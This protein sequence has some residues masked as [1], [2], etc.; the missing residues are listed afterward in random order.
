MLHE[1][2]RPSHTPL[3]TLLVLLAGAWLAAAGCGDA[4][5]PALQVDGLEWSEEELVGLTDE[6]QM[7]LAEIAALGLA[8]RRDSLPALVRPVVERETRRRLATVLRAEEA[9]GEADVGD[10]VLR[11]RY[12]TDPAWE[13]TV[14]HLIVLSERWESET[15]RREARAKAE[16]ALQRIRAGEDFPSVAA[17]VSEE[18]GAEGREGLLTPGRRGAWVPEFWNAAMT[19]D[20]GEV[21][22]VVETPYGF[23]VLRLEGR[24]TVPFE[25][26]RTEVA[27]EV[28]ELLGAD[29]DAPPPLPSGLEVVS[30]PGGLLAD[31]DAPD[32]TTVAVWSDGRLSLADLRDH[33]ATLL[34]PAAR[35]LTSSPGAARSAVETAARE[36]HAA[37]R[38]RERGIRVSDAWVDETTREWVDRAARWGAVL[39]LRAD[40]SDEQLR[41]AARRALGMTGQEARVAREELRERNPLIHHRYAIRTS[42]PGETSR[43]GDP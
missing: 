22:G 41:E 32:S 21:S 37:R 2:R 4:G 28:A 24:D 39:G 23:H 36:H 25:E 17:E 29:L 19:L 35:A 9:L 40:M 15:S 38:A 13:L 34:R 8:V 12:A 5:P 16:R 30:P 6:S 43:T 33:R 11:A 10:E 7:L 26:A 3:S 31:R 27:L 14:R 42:S 1:P 18:P 20:E